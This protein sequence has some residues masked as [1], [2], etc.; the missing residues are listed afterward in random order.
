[1]KFIDQNNGRS[2]NGLNST[3]LYDMYRRW[4]ER[5]N[6]A[7]GIPNG[8]YVDGTTEYLGYTC[9][10]WSN[11]NFYYYVNEDN[12]CLLYGGL[13]YNRQYETVEKIEEITE[14][15]Y[16][17]V[18]INSVQY[19]TISIKYGDGAD[20]SFRDDDYFDIESI[21]DEVSIHEYSYISKREKVTGWE[22]KL[23]DGSWV[24]IEGLEKVGGIW[25]YTD[26]GLK[27]YKRILD[28]YFDG[29]LEEVYI[30]AI[31]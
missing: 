19:T 3:S 9:T 18:D 14:I 2:D 4:E 29:N 15:P 26:D 16:G 1:M 23:T 31:I 20:S 24:K 27:T 6:E 17:A 7:G 25:G 12:C 21:H 10:I 22:V 5:F 8:F 13:G 11:G 28:E 30:R